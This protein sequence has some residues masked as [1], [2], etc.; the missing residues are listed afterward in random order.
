MEKFRHVSQPIQ[1]SV[2]LSNSADL[3][4]KCHSETL[5]VET[6]I[7][8]LKIVTLNSDEASSQMEQS[9][10]AS[11]DGRHLSKAMFATYLLP[12]RAFCFVLSSLVLLHIEQSGIDISY[13]LPVILL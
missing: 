9:T 7:K 10:T 8:G 2:H 6:C 11:V 1:L 13:Y 4:F 5:E 3:Y 12:Q